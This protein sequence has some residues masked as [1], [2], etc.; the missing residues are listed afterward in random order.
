[1]DIH[2]KYG[3]KL[4]RAKEIP[5]DKWLVYGDDLDTC[6]AISLDHNGVYNAH[7]H[8]KR[9]G[10]RILIRDAI[11]LLLSPAERKEFG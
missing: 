11:S 9:V 8:G 2:D 3:K 1:M 7:R 4:L 10:A 5:G 6:G